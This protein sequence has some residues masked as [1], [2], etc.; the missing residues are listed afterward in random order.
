MNKELIFVLIFA[1]ITCILNDN[2]ISKD[3]LN[4]IMEGDG[5]F[6]YGLWELEK[7]LINVTASSLI[8]ELIRQNYKFIKDDKDL[9]KTMVVVMEENLK[10]YGR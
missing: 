8:I 9:Y 2:D 10:N 4:A 7:Q 3:E 6:D 1:I 5:V